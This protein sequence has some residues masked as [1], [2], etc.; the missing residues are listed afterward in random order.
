MTYHLPPTTYHLRPT[1]YDLRPTTHDPRLTT[2]P[3]WSRDD[4]HRPCPTPAA[5]ERAHSAAVRRPLQAG[6][7]G[8]AA[9]VLPPEHVP[10][11]PRAADGGRGVHAV[12]LRR[13]RPPVPGH[14]RG[15]RHGLLR[16]FA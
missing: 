11:L 1:T 8:D 10:V 9:A 2:R 6:G 16:P 12:P 7:A 3:T 15:D 14:V 4:R 5:A 13:D